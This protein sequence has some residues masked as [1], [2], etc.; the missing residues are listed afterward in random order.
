MTAHSRIDRAG[1][2]LVPVEF[3]R[4]L[5]FTENSDLVSRVA[6]GE[7]CVHTREM[8]IP[9]ARERLERLKKPGESVVH[10]FPAERREEARR[11]L[12]E[13]DR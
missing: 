12:E 8:A 13:M 5:G 11:E 10:E 4:E 6:D 1:R 2:I 9:R 7:P 3:R